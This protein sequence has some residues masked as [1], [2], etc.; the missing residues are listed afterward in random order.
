LKSDVNR[1]EFLKITAGADLA[2]ATSGYC[3][4]IILEEPAVCGRTEEAGRF[5]SIHRGE[6]MEY[7]GRY[8]ASWG[9]GE[10]KTFVQ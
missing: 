6:S 8:M 9:S 2:M 1:R 3:M 7:C 4:P 10:K 5:F